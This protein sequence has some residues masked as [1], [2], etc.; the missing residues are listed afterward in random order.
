MSRPPEPEPPTSPGDAPAAAAAA[1]ARRRIRVAGGQLQREA[2]DPPD[3]LAPVPAPDPGPHSRVGGVVGVSRPMTLRVGPPTAP[4][5]ID[6]TPGPP[7]PAQHLPAEITGFFRHLHDTAQALSQHIGML[8]VGV[9]GREAPETEARPL[10]MS[11]RRPQ[12]VEP[13]RVNAKRSIRFGGPAEAGA[14]PAKGPADAER[15]TPL[16]AEEES[17]AAVVAATETEPSATDVSAAA[18]PSVP[19]PASVHDLSSGPPPVPFRPRTGYSPADGEFSP[20]GTTGSR[21][22]WG[23]VGTAFVLGLLGSWLLHR[24]TTTTAPPRPPAA[25]GKGGAPARPPANPAAVAQAT[26]LVG[27][28]L[29]AEKSGDIPKA[30]DLFTEAEK[31]HPDFPGIR[32]RLALL[33]LRQGEKG[34]TRTLLD[35]SLE[36]GEEVAA[37]HNL[38]SALARLENQ[39]QLGFAELEAATRAEPFNPKY[40]YFWSEALRR[41]G[42]QPEAA[43]KLE[44][45]LLR[46]TDP[47]DE[48]LYQFKLRLVKIELN[49]ESEFANDLAAWLQGASIAPAEWLLTA[50]ALALKREDYPGAAAQI[51]K[52]RQ[53]L[54]PATANFLLND[55]T[56]RDNSWR[57]ELAAFYGGP[58]MTT[59]PVRPATPP[60]PAPAPPVAI[61]PIPP[62]AP[63]KPAPTPAAVVA[64]KPTPTSTPTPAAVVAPKPSPPPAAT[65]PGVAKPLPSPAASRPEPTPTP[66]PSPSLPPAIKFRTGD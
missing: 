42:R 24:M 19:L 33:A 36:S 4:L 56:F 13:G 52:A 55:Q 34:K 53:L 30:V 8:T 26:E 37:V 47:T 46:A 16:N 41:A 18:D 48:T 27:Q 31:A 64:P 45:A 40:F 3:A 28:A 57:P 59:L 29:R 51:A 9:P 22:R 21:R 50:A 20:F 44:E 61:K 35:R 23:L 1:A 65:M 63:A 12:R 17:L 49:R 7:T 25:A 2:G 39:P 32:Y 62:S 14:P 43:A 10:P 5:V 15:P 38:Q 11:Q 66:L 54:S 6:S 58:L 60:A